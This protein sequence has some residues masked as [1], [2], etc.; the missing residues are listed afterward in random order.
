MS[1]KINL[2]ILERAES[3][4]LRLIVDGP[5]WTHRDGNFPLDP[6][7]SPGRCNVVAEARRVASMIAT[8]SAEQ[9]E[10]VVYANSTACLEVAL[11]AMLAYIEKHMPKG[12]SDAKSSAH[13]DRDAQPADADV[14]DHADAEPEGCVEGGADAARQ[15]K[16]A[17]N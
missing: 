11:K 1:K 13:S 16:K 12:K 8:R 14:V 3:K 15:R 17:R 2:D 7:I 9:P 6:G 5:A 4:G 10:D